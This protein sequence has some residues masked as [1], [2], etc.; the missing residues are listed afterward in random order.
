MLALYGKRKQYKTFAF[1][2]EYP[3]IKAAGAGVATYYLWLDCADSRG[4][5]CSYAQVTN[6]WDC[7][8]L[9]SYD[10]LVIFHFLTKKSRS[11]SQYFSND[12]DP[13]ALTEPMASLPLSLDVMYTP[14]SG[15][16]V[17]I[18][19]YLGDVVLDINYNNIAAENRLAFFKELF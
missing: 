11:L 6:I 1:I 10:L 2:S 8:G 19:S 3:L 14:R 17:L 18:V 5:G 12:L 15:L 16:V 7:N 9:G 13:K 4:Y